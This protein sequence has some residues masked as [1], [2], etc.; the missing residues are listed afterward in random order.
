MRW[1]QRWP[2]KRVRPKVRSLSDVQKNQILEA[3]RQGIEA[4]PV[5]SCLNI[6]VRLLRGRFYFERVRS[7]A[8]EPAE[9]EV[10]AR[11]TPVA[12]FQQDLLLEV[13]KRKGNWYQV[14]GGTTGEIISKIAD[15]SQGT[16]HGLGTLNK[17]LS[18]MGGGLIRLDVEMRDNFEFIYAQTGVECTVQEA[19][20]HFFGVPIDIISE[21]RQWYVY[22]R[23]P[24][25]VEV[26]KDRTKVLVQFTA[27]SLSGSRF[28]GRC[29]YAKINDEWDVFTIKPNQSN[30]IPEA[31]KWLEKRNWEEW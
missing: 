6:R 18:Q 4:S 26:S 17:N 23:K 9:V 24:E 28:G 22:H 10:I 16:F 27:E 19:L 2:E 14:A 12:D 13:E 7:I 5:L 20:F 21:P 25:I 31:I 30:S 11:I 15:D 3:F 1:K 8:D 29:L